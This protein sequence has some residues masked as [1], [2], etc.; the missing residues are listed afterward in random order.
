MWVPKI[1]N[2][3]ELHEQW[4]RSTGCSPRGTPNP[5][6]S[7]WRDL[8]QGRLAAPV[9]E[10]Q[11]NNLHTRWSDMGARHVEGPRDLV[12]VSKMEC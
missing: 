5:Q 7:V 11:S 6:A 8:W 2:D 1:D 12:V 9:K 4:S 3:G 10:K